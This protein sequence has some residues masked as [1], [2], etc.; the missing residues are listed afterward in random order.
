MTVTVGHLKMMIQHEATV[1]N[2]GDFSE[3]YLVLFHPG[4]LHSVKRG[5]FICRIMFLHDN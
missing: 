5:E 2:K 1:D 4:M 3:I